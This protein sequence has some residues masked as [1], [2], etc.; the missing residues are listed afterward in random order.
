MPLITKGFK[1][2][3]QR[4]Q[5]FADHGKQFSAADDAQYE[6]MADTF[7]GAPLAKFM[8]QSKRPYK[9]VLVRY[10]PMTNEFAMLGADG[11]IKTYFKPST[12]DHWLPRNLDYYFAN[13]VMFV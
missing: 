7:I 10:N 2:P 6:A 1:T 3:Q 13:S 5:H 12:A 8:L 11:H 4:K 9:N